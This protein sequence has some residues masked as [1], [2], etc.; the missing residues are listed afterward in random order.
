MYIRIIV[1]IKTHIGKV[2]ANNIYIYIYITL[3]LLRVSAEESKV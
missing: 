1:I 2:T 3:T